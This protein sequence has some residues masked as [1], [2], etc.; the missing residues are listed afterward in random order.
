MLDEDK[1][2]C[3]KGEPK[4]HIVDKTSSNQAQEVV[5]AIKGNH[6]AIY[7]YIYILSIERFFI[8]EQSFNF[9]DLENIQ[10]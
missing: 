6:S 10:I 4:I 8:D 2:L 5:G 7:I 3:V 9:L 1:V